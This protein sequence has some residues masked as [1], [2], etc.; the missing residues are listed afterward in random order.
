M[1]YCKVQLRVIN[2]CV[3]LAACVSE[4]IEKPKELKPIARRHVDAASDTKTMEMDYRALLRQGKREME[5]FLPTRGGSSFMDLEQKS[6]GRHGS[7][8]NCPGKITCGSDAKNNIWNQACWDCEPDYQEFYCEENS[9]TL[10]DPTYV[11]VCAQEGHYRGAYCKKFAEKTEPDFVEACF[12]PGSEYKQLY[13]DKMKMKGTFT[14]TCAQDA[15]VGK[16]YCEGF[17]MQK[18][19][20]VECHG[21]D[22]FMKLYCETMQ[23]ATEWDAN[24]ANHCPTGDHEDEDGCYGPKYCEDFAMQEEM[25]ADCVQYTSYLKLFCDCKASS[26][27]TVETCATNEHV[28]GLYCPQMAIQRNPYH[29][30]RAV[31]LFE[32]SYCALLTWVPPTFCDPYTSNGNR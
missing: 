28:K 21:W 20:F 16:G 5:G 15:D 14:A 4:P 13:C 10:P 23:N 30:C 26:N 27:T 24:C 17:A 18:R 19:G 9:L 32:E 22:G 31:R 6:T 2:V 8:R 7:E 29:P 25:K 3:L 11:D 12:F 1:R